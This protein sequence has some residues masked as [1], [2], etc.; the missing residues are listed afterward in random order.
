MLHHFKYGFLTVHKLCLLLLACFIIFSL[1]PAPKAMATEGMTEF[2][3]KKLSPILK[4]HHLSFP[5]CGL[6]DTNTAQHDLRFFTYPLDKTTELYGLL[7]DSSAF[8]T[9]FALYLVR[10]NNFHNTER[11]YFPSYSKALGWTGSNTLYNASYDP[12][13]KLL[14]SKTKFHGQKDCGNKATYKWTGKGFRL[15]AYRTKERCSRSTAHKWPL[16][17]RYKKNRQLVP[18]RRYS[19]IRKRRASRKFRNR[20][21]RRHRSRK[22][23]AKAR[24][25]RHKHLKRRRYI[26]RTRYRKKRAKRRRRQSLR[27]ARRKARTKKSKRRRRRS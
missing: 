18:N 26:R 17:Y 5:D 15:L 8:N 1:I 13:T 25:K 6:V 7:C 9:S 19:K 14:N 20:K 16:V 24:Y 2:Q 21:S 10:D 3:R 22:A 23:R 27:K 11:L 12:D 4:K